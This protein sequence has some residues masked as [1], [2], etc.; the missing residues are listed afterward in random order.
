MRNIHKSTPPSFRRRENAAAIVKAPPPGALT[1]GPDRKFPGLHPPLG[2]ATSP[3]LSTNRRFAF[4]ILAFLAVLAVGLLFLLP[5]GLLQAQEPAQ[6]P[7]RSV[8][9]AE[10]GEGPVLTLSATDPE[11]VT[12][13]VWGILEDDVG[14]QNLGIFTDDDMEDDVGDDDVADFADFEIEDGVLTFAI[15]AD[16]EP[17]DFESPADEGVNNEYKV[18]VQASDGGT[19]QAIAWF[20]VTVMVTDEEEDGKVSWTVDHNDE[21]TADSRS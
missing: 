2:G 20:K 14:V 10:N 16:K 13:I 12:P 15:G 19:M 6:S 11:G 17:P 8:E 18:V 7:Q 21:D 9:Y 1:K 5:G 3:S 4:P